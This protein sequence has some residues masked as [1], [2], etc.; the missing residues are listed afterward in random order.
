MPMSRIACTFD[1]CQWLS[2]HSAPAA[3]ATIAS[4]ATASRLRPL[5]LDGAAPGGLGAGSGFQTTICEGCRNAPA[6]GAGTGTG[7]GRDGGV[8][9]S[10][11]DHSRRLTGGGLLATGG[12]LVLEAFGVTGARPR[13]W[14]RRWLGSLTGA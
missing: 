7:T 3:S 14:L 5:E 2:P 6:S 13:P 10:W 9:I 8:T 1:C 11:S 4:S 12:R